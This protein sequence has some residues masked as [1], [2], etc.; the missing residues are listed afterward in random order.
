[1]AARFVA[2]ANYKTP[3][4]TYGVEQRFRQIAANCNAR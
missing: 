2:L 4:F 1:M 3:V